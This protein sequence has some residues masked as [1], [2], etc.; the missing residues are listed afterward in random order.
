[1]R[2][3]PDNPPSFTGRHVDLLGR[4]PDV[5]FDAEQAAVLRDYLSA[6]RAAAVKELKKRQSC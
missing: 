3:F 5:P 1:L 6:A 4:S 2:R